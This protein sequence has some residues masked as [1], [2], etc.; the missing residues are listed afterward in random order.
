MKNF[1]FIIVAALSTSCSQK[2]NCELIGNVQTFQNISIDSI[3]IGQ[4]AQISPRNFVP[5]IIGKSKVDSKGDFTYVLKKDKYKRDKNFN[6]YFTHYGYGDVVK[7][8]NIYDNKKIN[9]DT[10]YLKLK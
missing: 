5:G 7:T 2:I 9:L 10:I 8:I 3:E 4:M 1:I 6:I